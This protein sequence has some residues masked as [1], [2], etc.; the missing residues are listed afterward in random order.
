MT[1]RTPMPERSFEEFLKAES[2][3]PYMQNL[4]D[5]LASEISEGKEIFPKKRKRF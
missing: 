3:M 5:F 2:E 1:R 4:R